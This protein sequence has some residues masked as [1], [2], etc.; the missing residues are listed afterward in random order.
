MQYQAWIPITN[1]LY[2][3][4]H[5]ELLHTIYQGLPHKLGSKEDGIIFD[6][7]PHRETSHQGR[8]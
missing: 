8:N 7:W 5:T 2:S 4:Y 6:D 3:S 1:L